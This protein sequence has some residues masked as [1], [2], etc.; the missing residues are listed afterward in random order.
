MADPSVDQAVS[1]LASELDV[2][3]TRI[4]GILEGLTGQLVAAKDPASVRAIL[5][6]VVDRLKV[7]G[8]NPTDPIPPV[9]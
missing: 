8:T 3:T 7:L 2:E 1:E 5:Q 4:A 9:V 6:P